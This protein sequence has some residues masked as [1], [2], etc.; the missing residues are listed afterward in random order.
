MQFRP[1]FF[2]QKC[3][4]LNGTLGGFTY[5]VQEPQG[6]QDHPGK[7]KFEQSFKMPKCSKSPQEISNGSSHQQAMLTARQLQCP[8]MKPPQTYSPPS[9][10]FISPPKNT[11]LAGSDVF[12]FGGQ[13]PRTDSPPTSLLQWFHPPPP[14]SCRFVAGWNL[15]GPIQGFF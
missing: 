14:L 5:C 7:H 10:F 11:S 15:C 3:F 8:N 9:I 6:C 13:G 2:T 4:V 12:I 1:K